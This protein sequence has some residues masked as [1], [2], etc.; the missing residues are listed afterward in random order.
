MSS[1]V[2]AWAL[3]NQARFLLAPSAASE[4]PRVSAASVFHALYGAEA[5]TRSGVTVAGADGSSMLTTN[6]RILPPPT[7]VRPEVEYY[8]NEDNHPDVLASILETARVTAGYNPSSP[9]SDS[10]SALANQ[11]RQAFLRFIDEVDKYYH[12]VGLQGIETKAVENSSHDC[13]RL[14]K[15]VADVIESA[16]GEAGKGLTASIQ[17]TVRT[18]SER[19]TRNVASNS[20]VNVAY[21][22][23]NLPASSPARP[24]RD[25]TTAL[26]FSIV[27][28]TRTVQGSGKSTT[29]SISD[30]LYITVATYRLKSSVVIL[31]AELL[32]GSYII[33]AESVVVGFSSR[34]ANLQIASAQYNE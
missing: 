2:P 25:P 24:N 15:N 31:D 32:A 22:N 33:P 9:G 6:G 3:E 34:P 21:S 28:M 12:Y 19:V 17:H 7:Q 13:D 26:C 5:L 20:V 4:K 11:Q 30:Y 16:L 1:Q 14:V 27:G 29:D 8:R 18:A 23:V 10:N